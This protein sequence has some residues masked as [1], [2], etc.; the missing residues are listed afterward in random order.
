MSDLKEKVQV[1]IKS[2]LDDVEKRMRLQEH[3]TNS[4][5]ILDILSEVEALWSYLEEDDREFIGAVRFAVR[6]KMRW[7]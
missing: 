4:E 3:I 1:R 7:D 5:P 2:L 6:S